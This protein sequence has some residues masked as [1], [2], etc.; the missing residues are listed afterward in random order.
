MEKYFQKIKIDFIQELKEIKRPT[1]KIFFKIYA[2]CIEK[3]QKDMK[4]LR[5]LYKE[6][7]RN[8]QLFLTAYNEELFE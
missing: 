2:F 4:K 8:L 1:N 7:I 5:D 3:M 6:Y